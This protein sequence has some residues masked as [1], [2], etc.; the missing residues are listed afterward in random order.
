MDPYIGGLGLLPVE[1]GIKDMLTYYGINVSDSVVL[2]PH[3]EP[4]PV[5][6][7]REVGGTTVQEIQSMNY[8]FFV[9]VRPDGMKSD[10]MITSNLVAA[11][12]NW[13]SPVT[14]DADK[15]AN[16]E[17]E[18][19]LYSSP[20]SWT[21]D[22][23]SIQPDFQQYPDLGFPVGESQQSYPLAVTVKGVFNSYFADKPDPFEE[24]AQQQSGQTTVQEQAPGGTVDTYYTRILQSPASSRIVVFGSATF[25]DDFVIQLSSRL[26]QDRYLNSLQLFQNAVDWTVEDEDLLSIQ[27]R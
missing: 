18:T 7:N 20:Q 23:P 24:A 22:Q 10:S 6:V 16:R 17:V 15:N 2:D 21:V 8:P 27:S 13:V 19:L 9:D 5:A 12:M 3:N 1:G 26:S 11:T 4:F 25:I 14:V